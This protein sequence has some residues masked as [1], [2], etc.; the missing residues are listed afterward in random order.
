M[1]ELTDRALQAA[2]VMVLFALALRWAWSVVRPLMPVLVVAFGVW[3]FVRYL[4]HR[5]E[6]W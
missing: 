6:R 4:T 3:T 5:R 2:A 1:K